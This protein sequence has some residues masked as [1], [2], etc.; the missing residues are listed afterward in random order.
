M[1]LSSTLTRHQ[2]P[3]VFIAIHSHDRT[4]LP[5]Y[6]MLKPIKTHIYLHRIAQPRSTYTRSAAA[7]ST[8]HMHDPHTPLFDFDSATSVDTPLS[9][10]LN[11]GLQTFFGLS[12]FR[13]GQQRVIERVMH[14]RSTLALMPTGAGKS[15]CYQLPALLLPYATVVIS[16]LIALMKDQIDGLPPA[17]RE[18]STLINSSL[19]WSAIRDRLHDLAAGRYKLVYVA[20]ERLRQR[21]FLAALQQVG[22]SLFVVDEAHCVSL[23]G[24]SFRPDYLFIREALATLGS[25]PVLALTATAAPQTEREILAQLGQLEVVRTNV[26]RPNLQLE[27]LRLPNKDT[28]RATIE[29]WC[30]TIDGSIIIYVRSRAGCEELAERLRLAGMNAEAYHAQCPD[31][32][33]I[34]DRFMCGETRII[35]ATI[36]F[37]MGVDKPDVR[38]V[39]HANLSKSLDDYTQEAGRA[40]RDG[41]PARCILLYTSYDKIQLARWLADEAFSIDELRDVYRVV[42]RAVGQHTNIVSLTELQNQSGID[43]TRLRVGLGMLE[44]VG[45]LKRHFDAPRI[46]RIMAGHTTPHDSTIAQQLQPLGLAARSQ[47]WSIYE[48]AERLQQPLYAVEPW[49]LQWQ[50]AG[51]LTYDGLARDVTL[52]LLEPPAHTAE[53]MQTL[54]FEYHAVQQQRLEAIADYAQKQ[55][56]CRHRTMAAHFGQRLEPCRT[57]CDICLQGRANEA[58]AI[59]TQ[60]TFSQPLKWGTQPLQA[61]HQAIVDAVANQS[62]QLSSRDLAHILT[63]SR[64]YGDHPAFGVLASRSF[65]SIRA[66]IDVLVEAGQLAYR[67]SLLVVA[68]PPTS[69]APAQIILETLTRLPKGLGRSGLARLLKGAASAPIDATQSPDH[70]RLTHLSLEE[71]KQNIEQLITQ[72]FLERTDHP[73]YPLLVLT[74]NGK[75]H[76]HSL[77]TS[78]VTLPATPAPDPQL[79][80]RLKQWRSIEADRLGMP[81]YII[82]PDTVLYDLAAYQPMTHAELEAIKGIG[83]HK[84]ERWGDQLL[85]LLKN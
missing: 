42:R 9:H 23:W 8:L 48:L 62:A 46:I 26:F 56:R 27:V 3:D 28:L 29:Q 51:L 52:E 13:A 68:A 25:P 72:G 14:G 37:G 24:Q 57:A 33:A 79:L 12:G 66:E 82:F 18:Y 64:G 32:D 71:I 19:D 40:G 10:E 2:Q 74:P 4:N 84:I 61:H 60:P 22:L 70:G 11:Q 73:R 80:E 38:A 75:Q 59:Q 36:A 83:P 15:L 69:Q 16:P 77:S 67:G 85:Q 20:P 44:R 6:G 34:Q 47:E 49:L 54:L 1:L 39:I 78:P 30:A 65:D 7:E 53:H 35:A 55:R 45:V 21:Q 31:R 50:Q 58:P 63:G 81:R 76:L 17:V 41:L 5:E 43:E